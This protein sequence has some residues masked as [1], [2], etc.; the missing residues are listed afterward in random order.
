MIAP[1]KHIKLNPD[2]DFVQLLRDAAAGAAVIEVDGE[3]FRVIRETSDLFAN[4]D[5]DRA[6]AAL[7]AA[8]GT[9]PNDGIDELKRD[10]REM[11]EQDS[12]GR[13]AW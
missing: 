4:Y 5:P 10:L 8:F 13:P 11:R 2:S 6:L 7:R 9:L 12:A 1:P 3:R